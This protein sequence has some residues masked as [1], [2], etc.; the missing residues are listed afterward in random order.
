M[1]QITSTTYTFKTKIK[2][3]TLVEK[4]IKKE[5]LEDITR[6]EFKNEGFVLKYCHRGFIYD[7]GR[8]ST[9]KKF[10]TIFRVLEDD[11]VSISTEYAFLLSFSDFNDALK[12]NDIWKDFFKEL[13]GVESSSKEDPIIVDVDS[14]SFTERADK[15]LKAKELLDKGAISEFEYEKLKNKFI[16]ESL[17]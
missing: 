10:Q 6:S 15:L 2:L 11:T 16:E 14:D 12:I 17:K 8:T 13:D 7:H 9:L 3:A 4:I 5:G 1:G